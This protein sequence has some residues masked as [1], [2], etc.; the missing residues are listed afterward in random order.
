MRATGDTDVNDLTRAQSLQ[1]GHIVFR[2]SASHANGAASVFNFMTVGHKLHCVLMQSLYAS[3]GCIFAS[4]VC[5]F[6]TS[7]YIYATCVFTLCAGERKFMCGLRRVC[8]ASRT[9]FIPCRRARQGMTKAAPAEMCGG[10][11]RARVIAR[12]GVCAGLLISVER[13]EISVLYFQHI[14]LIDGITAG[15][16]CPV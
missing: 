5:I 2:L 4:F 12:G 13:K 15:H 3:C 11:R 10:S 7:V 8:P 1:S 9:V 16:D 14:H 6:A